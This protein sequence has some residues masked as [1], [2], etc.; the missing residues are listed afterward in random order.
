ME[1]EDKFLSLVWSK[2][3]VQEVEEYHF[4]FWLE[5]INAL[6]YCY[7]AHST[8]IF[9]QLWNA[10]KSP[11]EMNF[12]QGQYFPLRSHYLFLLVGYSKEGKS[13]KAK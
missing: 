9:L 10:T 2:L 1:N 7:V 6:F 5:S 12:D 13:N 8:K 4:K 11:L 3:F